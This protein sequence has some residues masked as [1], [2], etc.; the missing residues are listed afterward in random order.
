MKYLPINKKAVL[1]LIDTHCHILPG[2]DDGSPDLE[3]SANMADMARDDGVT[4]IVA[5]PHVISF[6]PDNR[7]MIEEARFHLARRLSGDGDSPRLLPGAEVPMSLCLSADGSTLREL[8]LAG[9]SCLLMETA[10][11][12]AEHIARAAYQ[13]RLAGLYPV[14]AHP[15]RWLDFRRERGRLEELL[16]GGDIYCQLTAASLEGVFGRRLKKTCLDMLGAGA[17]HLVASDAHGIGRRSP[18][19]SL[20]H[21][22]LQKHLGDEAAAHIMHENPGRILA[23]ERLSPAASR[24]RRRLGAGR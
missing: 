14:L 6:D 2:V 9:G 4:V 20:C 8:A 16:A 1:D 5:T 10:A 11:T 23:G 21:E 19:L 13:V 12:T 3:T 18:R 7:Q 22:I 24:N 17:A 15:E